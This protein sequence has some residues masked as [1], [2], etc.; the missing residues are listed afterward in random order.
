VP[1]ASF[2][3]PEI[4]DKNFALLAQLENEGHQVTA[5]SF[6]YPG[7]YCSGLLYPDHLLRHLLTCP[8]M[9]GS[10]LAPEQNKKISTFQNFMKQTG[11]PDLAEK[12][13]EGSCLEILY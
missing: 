10:N 11:L 3:G 1:G 12:L 5:L 13:S 7:L 2:T 6:T 4:K 9:M 8:G